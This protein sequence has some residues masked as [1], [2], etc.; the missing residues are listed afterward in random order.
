MIHTDQ[1]LNGYEYYVYI[2]LTATGKYYTGIS[3]DPV[4]RVYDHNHTKR[5]SKALRGQRP[6]ELVFQLQDPPLTKSQ[7]LRF[8]AKIKKLSHLDKE[9]FINGDLPLE[10]D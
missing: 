1:K 6:V 7:A 2:V 8:E 3:K 10:I 4:R 5:G 9:K